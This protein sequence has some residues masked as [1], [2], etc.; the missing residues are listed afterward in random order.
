[1]CLGQCDPSARE[2]RTN[3]WF[4]SRN[5]ASPS[6]GPLTLELAAGVTLRRQPRLSRRQDP[7]PGPLFR[8]GRVIYS[9]PY[10]IWVSGRDLRAGVH[11]IDGWRA[12][13]CEALAPGRDHRVARGP[14]QSL[15]FTPAPPLPTGG[16]RKSASRQYAGAVD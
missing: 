12:T 10:G 3:R 14:T 9:L 8:A 2:R 5:S 11:D 13:M 16:C 1:V 7:G 6:L 15:N 4:S